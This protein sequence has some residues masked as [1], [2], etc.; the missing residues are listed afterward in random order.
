MIRKLLFVLAIASSM[1]TVA[2][3]SVEQKLDAIDERL[4]RIEALLI[5]GAPAQRSSAA[6]REATPQASEYR[7]YIR[8]KILAN[9]VRP[10]S[11]RNGV[12]TV[13]EIRLAPTGEIVQSTILQTSGN[14]NFDR[15]ILDAVASA[16]SFGGLMNL[17]VKTFEENFR[18][19]TLSFSSEELLR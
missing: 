9:W 15:S 1:K 3:D 2:A 12:Q 4:A 14:R 13:L 11:A 16:K 17:P 18:T 5:N 8:D 10:P 19:L 7:E 6:P